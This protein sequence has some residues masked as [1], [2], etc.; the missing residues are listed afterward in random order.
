MD[1]NINLKEQHYGLLI[2]HISNVYV[3]GQKRVVKAVNNT[4]LN[5]YW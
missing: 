1:F 5:T 2:E 4:M 3:N